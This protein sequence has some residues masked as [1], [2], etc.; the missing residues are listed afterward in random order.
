MTLE[1]YMAETPAAAA[2]S[3]IV[4]GRPPARPFP[5]SMAGFALSV[6]VFGIPRSARLPGCS[7]LALTRFPRRFEGLN[8]PE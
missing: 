3:R 4:E 8:V 6:L 5:G 1:T 2:T 7:H